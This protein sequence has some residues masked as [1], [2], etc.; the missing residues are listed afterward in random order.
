MFLCLAAIRYYFP[1]KNW[2]LLLYIILYSIEYSSQ[3]RNQENY[4]CR[5]G[6]LIILIDNELHKDMK[7][8]IIGTLFSSIINYHIA[9]FVLFDENIIS[10]HLIKY[11]G[12]GLAS[13]G[14]YNIIFIP[15]IR[16]SCHQ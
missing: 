9:P 2:C 6:C 8:D 3:E 4:N 15:L 10:N 11:N 16:L 13:L 7:S 12:A 5:D 14:I 1:F